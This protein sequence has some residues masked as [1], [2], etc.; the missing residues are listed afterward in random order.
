MGG[1]EG[2]AFDQVLPSR[3]GPTLKG[4]DS[5]SGLP[6]SGA[7]SKRRNPWSKTFRALA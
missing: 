3:R 4:A 5:R 6:T 2:I 7:T 1:G